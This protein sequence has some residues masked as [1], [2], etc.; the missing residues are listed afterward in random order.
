MC[1]NISSGTVLYCNSSLEWCSLLYFDF[2][3]RDPPPLMMCIGSPLRILLH[4]SLRSCDYRLVPSCPAATFTCDIFQSPCFRYKY[5]IDSINNRNHPFLCILC[6]MN[7]AYSFRFIHVFNLRGISL[8]PP[9][10]NPVMILM[11]Q[12]IY[13][14]TA[15]SLASP[16]ALLSESH[17]HS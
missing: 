4:F 13:D 1:W 8:L 5:E 6:G 14:S 16:V 15:D 9:E 10:K 11:S 17:F 12:M 2:S 3:H 7:V